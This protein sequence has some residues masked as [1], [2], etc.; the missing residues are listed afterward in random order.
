MKLR[1]MI[2]YLRD[3]YRLDWRG[4]HGIAHWARVR[5]AGLELAGHTGADPEVVELFALLHDTCRYNDCHDPGHGPRAARLAEK[6]NGD[7]YCLDPSIL[8]LLTEAL[9][10]HTEGRIT[11]ER[12]IQTCWDADRLD[13]GRA[14]IRPDPR[15][16]GTEAAL[17]PEM[18]GRSWRRSLRWV[19]FEDRW[20][21]LG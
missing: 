5:A 13:L 18:I 10:G 6:L 3:R 21:R 2:L 20:R 15:R 9:H 19:R 8:G 1:S 12:T 4:L 11:S 7:Y 14:G 17:D 16:L